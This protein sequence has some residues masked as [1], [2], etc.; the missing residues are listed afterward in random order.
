MNAF[1]MLTRESWKFYL[2]AM[3]FML[4]FVLSDT[5]FICR[6]SGIAFMNSS[7]EKKIEDEMQKI[8][9]HGGSVEIPQY[10]KNLAEVFQEKAENVQLM[11]YLVTIIGIIVLLLARKFHCTDMRV[12]E[13]YKTLPVREGT[14]VLYDYLLIL[15]IIVTGALVQGAI[16]TGALT[17]YN[18]TWVMLASGNLESAAASEMIH[19]ANEYT[20]TFMLCYVLFIIVFYTWIY[21]GVT[22]MKNPIAGVICSVLTWFLFYQTMIFYYDIFFF[23]AS[24]LIEEGLSQKDYISIFIESFLLPADFFYSLDWESRTMTN[25]NIPGYSMWVNVWAMVIF[26]LVLVILIVVAANKR[27]LSRGKLFYF[28]LLDYPFSILCGLGIC[29]ILLEDFNLG[30]LVIGFVSAVLVYLFI[31]PSSNRKL[32]NW[33]VK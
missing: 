33:E 19:E 24:M 27:E 28:P 5:V 3:G 20:L 6:D 12:R 25:S 2:I 1:R 8:R 18:R 17:N 14:R 11:G 22:V 30:A 31:H 23:D 13:F 10:G 7:V 32:H 15:F 29:L 21:L 16:V 9:N 4:I 26:I